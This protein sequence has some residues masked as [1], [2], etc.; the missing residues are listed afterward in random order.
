MGEL[1]LI[2]FSNQEDM[3]DLLDLGKTP[4]VMVNNRV[5]TDWEKWT[6]YRNRQKEKEI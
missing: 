6:W 1:F 2:I 5:A 4:D 3:L